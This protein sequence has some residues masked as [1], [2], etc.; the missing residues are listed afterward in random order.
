MV[1]S[2]SVLGS[3]VLGSAEFGFVQK[4]RAQRD[5][6]RGEKF[7]RDRIGLKT[8]RYLRSFSDVTFFKKLAQLFLYQ[9]MRGVGV[10]LPVDALSGQLLEVS[11]HLRRR[12][13]RDLHSLLS[14]F[15]A[16]HLGQERDKYRVF[17]G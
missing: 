1:G 16:G 9:G 14:I 3:D 12:R 10:V 2:G 15:G 7:E 8:R 13:E 6:V 11:L 4:G 5:V 17:I